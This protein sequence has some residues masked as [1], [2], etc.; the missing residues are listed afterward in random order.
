VKNGRRRATLSGHTEAVRCVAFSPDGKTLASAGW[1]GTVH[2]WEVAS[3]KHRGT[4]D[5]GT[6]W[7]RLSASLAGR[8]LFPRSQREAPPRSRV[9][10]RLNPWIRSDQEVRTLCATWPRSFSSWRCCQA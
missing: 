3:W 1:D 5:C 4:G 7:G 8:M 2:L 9:S 6:A 10:G